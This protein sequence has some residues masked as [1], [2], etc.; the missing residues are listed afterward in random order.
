MNRINSGHKI[1]LWMV[2]DRNLVND[3]PEACGRVWKEIDCL[4]LREKDWILEET[5]VF[6][7]QLTAYDE[8]D[9][10]PV[11]RLLNWTMAFEPWTLPID[12]LHI[13]IE[14]AKK[15][16]Q[17]FS[18][19][20]PLRKQM[21]QKHWCLGISIHSVE[22]WHEIAEL[23]PDYVLISNVFKTDCKP[24]KL[25]MGLENLKMM[26][27]A[28]KMERPDLLLIGLGGLKKHHLTELDAT[29]L[30][31]IALRSELHTK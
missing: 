17:A 6:F 25:G 12:G 30:N 28:I 29:G 24:G 4:I 26:I 9:Q 1:E 2:T 23:Q 10:R 19:T 3:L 5:Q 8:K 7:E 11:R 27:G 14:C 31:G 20:S 15:N 16:R 22:E 13:G 18:M 21:I